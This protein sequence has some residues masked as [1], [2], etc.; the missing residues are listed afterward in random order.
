MPILIPD[1]ISPDIT[2]YFNHSKK[3][4]SFIS[5]ALSLFSFLSIL[6]IS[7][8]ILKDF[9]SKKHPNAFY[10]NKFMNDTGVFYLNQTGIFHSL[11]FLS[12][13]KYDPR[14][15][16]IIGLRNVHSF[17][18]FMDSNP[19]SYDH[20]IYD[21]CDIK[22]F[23]CEIM[24]SISGYIDTFERGVCISRF[25]NK[26]TNS[27]I[28]TNDPNFVY[29]SIEHGS[30]NPDSVFYGMMIQ[31]CRN[32][33]Y[34][35]NTCYPQDKI[36]KYVASL[37][38]YSL[39]FVDHNV[40]VDHYRNPYSKY[41]SEVTSIFSDK[42]SFT[43]NNVNFYPITIKT[44]K[45]VLLDR[46]EESIAY[47]YA[48]NEKITY[49]S[50]HTGL[51]GNIYFWMPNRIEVYSRSYRKIQDLA[52][53]IGGI[54]KFVI[55]IAK[56]L[57]FIYNDYLEIKDFNYEMFSIKKKETAKFARKNIMISTNT[58]ISNSCLMKSSKTLGEQISVNNYITKETSIQNSCKKLNT[59]QFNNVNFFSYFSFYFLHQKN[60]F[61]KNLIRLRMKLLSEEML[62][63]KYNTIKTLKEYL[64]RSSITPNNNILTR[65]SSIYKSKG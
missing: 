50:E 19:Y 20:W 5:K 27:V 61:I 62:Y 37:V 33:S 25:Y 7:G 1:I 54:A 39:Y 56:L 10:Y 48:L 47:K 29:P 4:S 26:T 45:G 58:N 16:S 51:I 53:S 35:N 55:F 31:M 30:I 34:N 49:S 9:F 44:N 23:P 65:C 36:D 17:G 63:K 6:S 21:L 41:L 11:T 8:I 60:T 14:A 46:I 43:S 40:D 2:L 38:G 13:V 24:D 59:Y 52:G 12:E 15:I 64:I 32:S 18:F 42:T 3:H 28:D 22:T 57:N